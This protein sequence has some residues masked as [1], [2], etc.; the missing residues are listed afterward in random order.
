[1]SKVKIRQKIN[2]ESEQLIALARAMLEEPALVG[3]V[4]LDKKRVVYVSDPQTPMS[5]RVSELLKMIQESEKPKK[6]T[7]WIIAVASKGRK[8][9]KEMLEEM[10]SRGILRKE[11]KKVLWVIPYLEYS[12]QDASVKYQRKQQL[13]DIV[14]GGVAADPESVALLSLLKAAGLLYNIFTVDEIKAA[15]NTVN[16]IVKDKA[17]G[18]AVVEISDSIASAAIAAALAAMSA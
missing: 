10:I 9:E 18:A 17:I 5:K 16:K 4:Q 6:I 8:L 11:E 12:Q 13:R 15:N 1:M 7:H 14:P 3:P 2:Q